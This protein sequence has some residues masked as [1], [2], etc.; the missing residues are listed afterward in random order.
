[1]HGRNADNANVP[2]NAAAMIGILGRCTAASVAAFAVFAPF[3]WA[4]DNFYVMRTDPTLTDDHVIASP[5]PQIDGEAFWVAAEPRINSYGFCRTATQE[6]PDRLTGLNFTQTHGDLAVQGFADGLKWFREQGLYPFGTVSLDVADPRAPSGYPVFCTMTPGEPDAREV[7]LRPIYYGY[8]LDAEI[9]K[10]ALYA[11]LA[12]PL[13]SEQEKRRVVL[14]SSLA[15]A[16]LWKHGERGVNIAED[17]LPR[18]FSAATL[19]ALTVASVKA[20]GQLSYDNYTDIEDRLPFLPGDYSQRLTELRNPKG[21]DQSR[22]ALIQY[23]FEDYLELPWQNLTEIMDK[24]S[25]DAF[26][27]AP[28]HEYL[29]DRDGD[30]LGLEQALPGFIAYHASK[31]FDPKFKRAVPAEQWLTDSV[32]AC[33]ELTVNEAVITT[34]TSVSVMPYAARC[35]KVRVQAKNIP[36]HGDAQMRLRLKDG[37]PGDDRANEVFVSFAAKGAGSMQQSSLTCASLVEK[38]GDANY[39]IDV[40]T[41]QGADQNGVW[42]RIHQFGIEGKTPGEDD[43]SIMLVNYV[44]KN[45]RL[46]TAENR[47]PLNVEVT[48]SLDVVLD[49]A[50][51]LVDLGAS[52][53]GEFE[54]MDMSTA[55][56]THGSKSGIAPIGDGFSRT[57]DMSFG[58]IFN[59]TA[60]PINGSILDDAISNFDHLIEFVDDVGDGF[61]FIITDPSVLQPGFT[62]ATDAYVPVAGKQGFISFPDPDYQGKIEIYE[63]TED[64]L[65]FAAEEGFCMVP[66]SEW[67]RLMREANPDLCEFGERVTAKAKGALAFPPLRRSAT[68]LE[69]KETES[70]TVLKSLRLAR[71]SQR[72]GLDIGASD[73]DG[74]QVPATPE[75]AS[76]GRPGTARGEAAI[77]TVVANTGACDC[78]CS[79]KS[80]FEQKRSTSTLTPRESAC[81]LSCGKRWGQC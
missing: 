37:A 14:G 2:G 66:E 20:S 77:C 3:I 27:V 23:I 34:T 65:Y 18:W 6:G 51:E 60:T 72:F 9:T 38:Y 35:F 73:T 42:Q 32:G 24:M 56:I 52:P 30:L 5:S 41:A 11:K 49:G 57:P 22:G 50:G 71:I 39:C 79:A 16:E 43:W 28:L 76:G 58:A 55:T 75:A 45:D 25:G 21:E 80:C 54:L 1:M 33:E 13:A 4:Q 69:P 78:S 19:D 53:S 62:G 31:G 10:A 70:Y 64:T 47:P 67:P 26:P 36:W 74:S 68:K 40:P 44:P 12:P 59:G 8:E 7:R 61:G 46:R 29:D 17:D 81:R 48:I 15:L 63:N